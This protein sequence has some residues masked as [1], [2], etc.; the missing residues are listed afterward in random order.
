RVAGRVRASRVNVSMPP[1][2]RREKYMRSILCEACASYTRNHD[3]ADLVAAIRT[4]C[5]SDGDSRKDG[6]RGRRPESGDVDPYDGRGDL[7]VDVRGREPRRWV[8][9]ASGESLALPDA[10]RSGDRQFVAVLFS[11]AV[12]RRGVAR[13]ADRQAEC[14]CR[15][16]A[17][18]PVSR[19]TDDRGEGGG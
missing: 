4:V 5:R 7:H 18:Q 14:R 10:L 12:D 13:G 9:Y 19:R 1:G 16:R 2:K 8:R 6:R 17:G 15:D 11:R 3:V